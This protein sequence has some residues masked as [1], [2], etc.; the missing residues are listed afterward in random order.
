MRSLDR[1]LVEDLHSFRFFQAV[2]LLQRLHPDRE[3][4]GYFGDPANEILRFGSNPDLAF[5]ASEIDELFDDGDEAP[6]RMRVNFMGLVGHMGVLPRHYS[7]LVSERARNRHPALLDFLDLFHHRLVSLFYRAWERYRFYAPFERGEEDPVTTHLFDLVGL[8]DGGARDALELD[9]RRL[10]PYVG[11]LATRQ[12]SAGALEQI[13]EDYFEVPI[14]V[15]QFVGAWYDVSESVQC[16][17]DDEADDYSSQLGLGALVGDEIW[18]PNSRVRLT[19]GPLPLETYREFL[20][21]G[22]AY[23]DLRAITRFFCNDE[24]EFEVKLILERGDVPRIELGKDDDL[25]LGWST[26]LRSAPMARDADDTVL[27][28]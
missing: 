28:L 11:L 20:P 16:R 5:P 17:V 2:R 1:E 25:P 26:W 24:I 19:L 15:E 23:R 3:R 13:L 12:R 6:W 14:E 18:D 8:G 10:L 4:V 21:T 22:S 9:A 7:V 27:T